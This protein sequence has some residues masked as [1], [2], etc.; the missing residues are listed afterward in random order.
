[1]LK[2]TL[3]AAF[4]LLMLVCSFPVAAFAETTSTIDG[5][6]EDMKALKDTEH[7]VYE[8]RRN[9]S[10]TETGELNS[11]QANVHGWIGGRNADGS[12]DN[13][14]FFKIVLEEH[15]YLDFMALSG[16][17]GT[18]STRFRLCSEDGEVLK[19]ATC[20]GTLETEGKSD[21]TYVMTY[22]ME[23]GTY[24]IRVTEDQ[25]NTVTEYVFSYTMTPQARSP[26]VE[27]G[28]NNRKQP[29]LS[30]KSIKGA[31]EYR[32]YRAASEN[33]IYQC[34]GSVKETSFADSTA[35][36]GK[37]YWYTVK[38]ITNDENMVDSKGSVPVKVI[39]R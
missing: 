38:A 13:Y 6:P 1:M 5:I 39:C 19:W 32:V 36:T 31:A 22:S 37:T 14:D 2:R 34:L 18:K 21:D 10:E 28:K 26:E 23:P 17:E 16:A 7:L 12:K 25:K 29:Q 33:D 9:E 35:E 15:K 24:F 3:C 27:A 20:T 4:A 30:W 11:K 8:T